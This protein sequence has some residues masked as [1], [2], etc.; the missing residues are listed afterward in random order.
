ML[1][2]NSVFTSFSFASSSFPSSFSS[3]P[4]SSDSSSPDSYSSSY[5]YSYSYSSLSNFI[6][7]YLFESKSAVP[8]IESR[9]AE[10]LFIS[11]VFLYE[12]L[13][14][15]SLFWSPSLSDLFCFTQIMTK[16]TIITNPMIKIM[17]Q[18]I[19]SLA[20]SCDP[21]KLNSTVKLKVL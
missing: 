9:L 17:I 8:L 6:F 2:H 13:N 12:L 18:M 10:D 20:P 15:D 16:P 19:Y 21:S 1:H 5:Y 7:V 3:D 4:S 11:T 14:K